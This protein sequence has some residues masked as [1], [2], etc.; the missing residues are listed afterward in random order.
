MRRPR[1][2]D[3]NA[4]VQVKGWDAA[5]VRHARG[6]PVYLYLPAAA[7]EVRAAVKEDE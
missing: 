1:H 7:T 4:L 3:V 2:V 6:L 5:E